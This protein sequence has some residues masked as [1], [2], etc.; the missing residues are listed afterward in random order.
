MK[1]LVARLLEGQIANS[2]AAPR[3]ALWTPGMRKSFKLDLNACR[4]GVQGAPIFR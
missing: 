2:S 4:A 3:Q 1:Q